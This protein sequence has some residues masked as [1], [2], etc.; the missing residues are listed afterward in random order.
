MPVKRL[1]V[2]FSVVISTIFLTTSVLAQSQYKIK[3]IVIDAGHGGHD[4]GAVAKKVQEKDIA[5]AV[6]LKLGKYIN[7]NFK[8]VEVIYTR[9]TDVFVE[10]WDRA[11]IANDKKADLFISIHCNATTSPKPYGTETFVMGLAKT[12][13]NLRMAQRENAVI[14]LEQDYKKQYNS[15]DPNSAESYIIFSLFQSVYRDQSLDFASRIQN[16]FKTKILRFDRGVK[17]APYLVLWQSTMPSVLIETGFLSNPEEAKFLA[18]S[19]GQD[20]IALSIFKAIKSYK[21]EM[22]RVEGPN[23]DDVIKPIDSV[24]VTKEETQKP[25]TII[26]DSIAKEEIIFSVQF[27]TSST[28]KPS[29]AESFNG[30]TEV[31]SYQQDN[32]YKYV[33]GKDKTLQTAVERMKAIREKGFKEAFVVAFK[34]GKRI[35][36]TEAVKLIQNQ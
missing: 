28:K 9:K 5:L 18:S 19:D 6:A 30:I 7:D 17:E 16:Q 26:S 34:N 27:T 15:F 10:L 29:N 33:S 24:A 11:K 1:F 25:T 22:E 21:N 3:R 35:S 36:P 13:A 32:V 8:D 20:K 31:W 4:P 23:T 14:L 12:E 2:F